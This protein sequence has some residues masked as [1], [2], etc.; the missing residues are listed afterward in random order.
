MPS[1]ARQR[2]TATEV[3]LALD[4]GR[5]NSA[6]EDCCL[7]DGGIRAVSS[8]PGCPAPP[9]TAVPSDTN[10]FATQPG[11][12]KAVVHRECVREMG[13]GIF[14][15]SEQRGQFAHRAGYGAAC[16]QVPVHATWSR[17]GDNVS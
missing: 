6:G 4:R 11:A 17:E 15:M 14:E 1:S 3:E 7:G 2:R 9:T 16:R 13:V 12:A 10:V 8:S 5:S